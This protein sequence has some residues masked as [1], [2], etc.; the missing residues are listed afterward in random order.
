MLGNLAGVGLQVRHAADASRHRAVVRNHA[1]VHAERRE[2]VEHEVFH[3]LA[4]KVGG[5]GRP[6]HVREHGCALA[7]CVEHERFRDLPAQLAGAGDEAREGNLENL[8]F[9]QRRRLNL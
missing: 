3:L 1:N 2:R 5:G 4:A 9:D 8:A 6:R 7:V